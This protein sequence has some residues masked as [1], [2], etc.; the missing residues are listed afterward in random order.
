V[1][2]MAWPMWY[3]TKKCVLNAL[4]RCITSVHVSTLLLVEMHLL[5]SHVCTAARAKPMALFLIV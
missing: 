3:A 5:R 2:S 1:T 4:C